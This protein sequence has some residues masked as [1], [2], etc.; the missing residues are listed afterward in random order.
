MMMIEQNK[1][2][3]VSN[4]SKDARSQSPCSDPGS[5]RLNI[6]SLK[7]PQETNISIGSQQAVSVRMKYGA[8]SP[9]QPRKI[10][11]D[12]ESAIQNEANMK[13]HEHFSTQHGS[14]N[15]DQKRQSNADGQNLPVD[16]MC[17]TPTNHQ[18]TQ[19]QLAFNQHV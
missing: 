7:N 15:I 19:Q 10:N 1:R 12:L 13:S 17:Y 11:T 8:S 18:D 9:S 6:M 3:V 5:P 14:V 16:S 2:D 4:R